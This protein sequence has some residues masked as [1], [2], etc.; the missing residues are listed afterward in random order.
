M[1]LID[2]ALLSGVCEDRLVYILCVFDQ[3]WVF[4]NQKWA[5][6]P[7]LDHN[8]WSGSGPIIITRQNDEIRWI[9]FYPL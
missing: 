3:L 4:S 8:L 6:F 7:D 1:L 2:E 5:F 9:S